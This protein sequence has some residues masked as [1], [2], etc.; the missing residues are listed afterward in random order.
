[1]SKKEHLKQGVVGSAPAPSSSASEIVVKREVF[2]S[3]EFVSLYANDVQIQ[4]TPWDMRLM[5]GEIVDLPSV[6]TPVAKIKQLADLRLSPQLAK[7]P[8]MVMIGQLEAYEEKYGEIP[9]QKD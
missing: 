9:L 7:K 8:A 1:M 3:P 2:R 5:L 6:E 4:I